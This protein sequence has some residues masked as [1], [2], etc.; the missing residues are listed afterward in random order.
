MAGPH[1]TIATCCGLLAI[2]WFSFFFFFLASLPTNIVP[3]PA[4]MR[5]YKARVYAP[6]CARCVGVMGR[7]GSVL[8]A[9]RDRA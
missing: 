1:E 9:G 2:F 3:L 7:A 6:K 8:A 5:L 4:T